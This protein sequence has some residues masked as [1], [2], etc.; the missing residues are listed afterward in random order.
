[1]AAGIEVVVL[2]FSTWAVSVI[3]LSQGLSTPDMTP[4]CG[5]R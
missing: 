1:M 5:V 3:G 2:P 4:G